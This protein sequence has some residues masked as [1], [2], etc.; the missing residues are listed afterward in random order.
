MY[1][2]AAGDLDE[3]TARARTALLRAGASEPN[4]EAPNAPS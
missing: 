4:K 1:G 2:I 3:M